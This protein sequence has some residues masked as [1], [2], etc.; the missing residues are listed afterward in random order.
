VEVV[1][2]EVSVE[3][4]SDDVELS[5]VSELVVVVV[6]EDSSW[7]VSP[8]AQPCS[9]KTSRIAATAQVNAEMRVRRVR[10]VCVA[11][12][13][14]D[15]EVVASADR[16]MGASPGCEAGTPVIPKDGISVGCDEAVPVDCDSVESGLSVIMDTSW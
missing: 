7:A 16:E 4:A 5:S 11:E 3:E 8:D 15:C 14:V 10:Q 2:S 13:T 1:S 9:A 12:A 6:L